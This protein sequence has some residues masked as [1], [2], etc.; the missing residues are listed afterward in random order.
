MAGFAEEAVVQVGNTL[1]LF[2]F[3]SG[4]ETD[5]FWCSRADWSDY[6]GIRLQEM[7]RLLAHRKMHFDAS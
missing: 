2:D 7:S 4:D 5:I 6:A 1:G 3:S